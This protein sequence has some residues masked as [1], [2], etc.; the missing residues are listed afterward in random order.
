MKISEISNL[1]GRILITSFDLS[2]RRSDKI[3]SLFLKV[4]LRLYLGIN[5]SIVSLGFLNDLV[6]IIFRAI[7]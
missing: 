2:F 5:N 3:K 1:D 6:K 7:K 4:K